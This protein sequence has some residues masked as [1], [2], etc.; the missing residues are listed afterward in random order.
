LII[1]EVWYFLPEEVRDLPRYE[2]I[3]DI[4]TTIHENSL[5]FGMSVQIDKKNTI[6]RFNDCFFCVVYLRAADFVVAVPHSV[7]IVTR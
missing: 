2:R 7:E 3:V 5:L 4:L 1:V 6:L